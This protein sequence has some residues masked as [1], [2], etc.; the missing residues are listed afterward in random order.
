MTHAY[1]FAMLAAS[2]L[3]TNLGDLW[4]DVLLPGRLT[5]LAALLVVCAAA[6][7][8][9]DRIAG[10]Q[11]EVRLQGR[12]RRNASR[13]DQ[14]RGLHDGSRSRGWLCRCLGVAWCF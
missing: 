8:A 9:Y 7:V 13:R 11:S 5:S 10:A 2:A 4:V 6:A 12:N 3:G 14:L 1:W